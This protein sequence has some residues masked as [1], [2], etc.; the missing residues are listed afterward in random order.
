M[1][2]R[3]ARVE[4]RIS[5]QKYVKN[6]E[7]GRYE[8]AGV[9][10][11]RSRGV[12]H[13]WRQIYNKMSVETSHLAATVEQ[14]QLERI[15]ELFIEF[16]NVK[17]IASEV[18]LPPSLVLQALERFRVGCLRRSRDSR[19]HQLDCSADAEGVT[20]ASEDFKK[21]TRHFEEI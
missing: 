18:N 11:P 21:I 8:R 14:A 9:A 4:E 10:E 19:E 6:E 3:K 5:N 12:I 15:V 17:R 7:S 1:R 2:V 13:N 16:K 20:I